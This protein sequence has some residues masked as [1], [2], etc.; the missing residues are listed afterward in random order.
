MG[1]TRKCVCSPFLWVYFVVQ[2]V[3]LLRLERKVS[4]VGHVKCVCMYIPFSKK[5]L[6]TEHLLKF[7]PEMINPEHV[8]V[9]YHG[10]AAE[11][12]SVTKLGIT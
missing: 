12:D 11:E 2:M 8:S 4:S 10:N 9:F 5:A 1:P 7:Q 3:F 6:A